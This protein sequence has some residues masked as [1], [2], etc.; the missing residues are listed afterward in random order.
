MRESAGRRQLRALIEDVER[1][2]LSADE[3][4]DWFSS[5]RIWKGPQ[6]GPRGG[7]RYTTAYRVDVTRYKPF[8]MGHAYY[9]PTLTDA[10][11]TA[12]R[13]ALAYKLSQDPASKR[14]PHAG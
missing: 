6:A 11:L 14:P 12:A 8:L 10:I 1:G 3:L 2:V 4:L 13:D 9:Q 5:Y 7:R